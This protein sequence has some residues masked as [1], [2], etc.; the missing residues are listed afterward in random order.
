ML[1][2]SAAAIVVAFIQRGVLRELYSTLLVA[3]SSPKII[4]TQSFLRGRGE[5]WLRYLS[6]FTDFHPYHWLLGRGNALLVGN[7]PQYVLGFDEPHNDFLR[8]LY[9]YGTLGLFFYLS[10]LIAFAGMALY[11]RQEKRGSFER[12][13]AYLM[14]LSILSIVV[15]SITTEPMRYPTSVWYFFALG[16]VIRMQYRRFRRSIS[17]RRCEE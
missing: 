12:N 7:Y 4:F 11:L 9:T 1:V 17:N 15:L 3:F 5:Q 16:S 10:T 6:D 14:L 13:L 8:I 2:A